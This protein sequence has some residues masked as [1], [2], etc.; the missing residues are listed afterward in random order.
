MKLDLL[1]TLRWLF[2]Q[3]VNLSQKIKA[4]TL[5]TTLSTA[6][7]RVSRAKSLQHSACDLRPRGLDIGV[8][9]AVSL[10]DLDF[11]EGGGAK[12]SRALRLGSAVYLIGWRI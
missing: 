7:V 8:T 6:E 9:G 3:F 5:S 1:L 12:D 4:Q 2:S 10:S 11:I